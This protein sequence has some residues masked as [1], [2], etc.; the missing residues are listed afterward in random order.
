[1]PPLSLVC[2]DLKFHLTK[3]D[4]C[5]TMNADKTEGEG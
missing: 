3:V 4:I 1:M 5:D 2:F